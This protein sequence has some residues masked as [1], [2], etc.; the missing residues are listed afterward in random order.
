M[1]QKIFI[2]LILSTSAIFAKDIYISS[3][4]G[5]DSNDGSISTPL[6]TIAKAPKTNVNIFLKRGDVFY[7][8]PRNFKNSNIDAY[9]EGKK[10]II[11]GFKI[12]KNKDAW[13]KMP[14]DIWRL[15]LTDDK[16]FEGYKTS[17][18]QNNL[19]AVYDVKNDK[20]YGHL[21]NRF[22]A[23]NNDGDFFVSNNIW[24]TDV[25]SKNETFKYLFFKSKKSP[26]K[27]DF[28]FSFIPYEFGLRNLKNCVVKNIAIKGFG[29]HG[30][31]KAWGCTFQNIDIDLIGGSVQ[32][33][34]PSWVRLGNAIEF[35]ISDSDPCSNNIVENCRISRTYDCGSTIQGN[36]TKLKAAN[37]VFRNNYFFRCRQAFEHFLHSSKV[38]PIYENC[39]FS[40]NK[41]FEMGQNDFS[42]PEVR[43]SNILSYEDNPISGLTIKNNIFWGAPHYCSAPQNTAKCENNTIYIFKGQFLS[44]Y[45]KNLEETIFANTEADVKKMKKLIGNTTDKIVIV[46]PDDQ[47]LREEVIAE[48]FSE[49]KSDIRKKSPVKYRRDFF[50][51]K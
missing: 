46:N 48:F 16:N 11:C 44:F 41:C 8:A 17:G 34:Y 10:P 36:G 40:N 23:L 14:N 26:Q 45:Y 2:L 15:D 39:E 51:R 31:S 50:Y 32:L 18:K 43:D 5:D 3:S 35:W 30:I 21:V 42:T 29:I 4:T 12:L 37:I 22:S 27:N 6:K 20:L 49:E 47:R 7:E 13:F 19:G 9:G 38:Q 28:K 25:R 24:R 33:S 1:F